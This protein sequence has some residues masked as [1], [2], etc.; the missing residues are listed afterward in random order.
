M[1][2][3][4][5]S[6]TA[7]ATAETTS[8]VLNG[9]WEELLIK[10]ETCWA[11]VVSNSMYPSITRGD[12]VLVETAHTEKVRFGDIV[13][14]KRN[15]GLITHRVIGK[16]EFGGE[17]HFLEK[18]DAV[19]RCSLVSARDVIGRV[20]AI[21]TSGKTLAIV[22]GVGRLLQLTLACISCA[23]LAPMAMLRYCRIRSGHRSR[24]HHY[25][26]VYH[27]FLSL[28]QRIALR[29]LSYRPGM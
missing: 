9:L 3:L 21:S 24:K 7:S 16:R 6:E 4:S 8:C 5:N 15:G 27:R 18:G 25:G 19:L 22:S 20:T 10:H 11:R 1:E 28:L 14:F 17:R 29:L 12:E 2:A 23:S 26:A 13:V